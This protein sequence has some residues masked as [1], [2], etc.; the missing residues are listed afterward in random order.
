MSRTS[1]FSF[2]RGFTLIELLIV[3]GIIGVLAA[4]TI[5]L[6]NPLAQIQKAHDAQRKSD[7]S[8]IQKALEMYYQDYNSYPPSSSD[9]KIKI[10]DTTGDGTIVNWGSSWAPF[11]STLPSDPSSTQNY[12][13]FSDGQ[14]YRL[15]ASLERGA[16]DPQT[17]N[18]GNPCASL[19][20]G[21][22]CGG[23]GIVCNYGTSSPNVSL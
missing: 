14:A 19:P 6:L 16:N 9:F 7:F 21:A 10:P 4:G 3:I 11:M 20:T 13:Y 8:E 2:S 23:A 17:C 22:T 5:V 15:Y 12:V 1:K 18:G